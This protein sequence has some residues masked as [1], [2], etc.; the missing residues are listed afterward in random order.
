MT[1]HAFSGG[2]RHHRPSRPAVFS[3][4]RTDDSRHR[5]PPR[6][7]GGVHS[8]AAARGDAS[9]HE[10]DDDERQADRF[11]TTARAGST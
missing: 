9:L 7:G 3:R 5:P 2:T 10:T 4:T 6:L 11:P 8:C 1:F